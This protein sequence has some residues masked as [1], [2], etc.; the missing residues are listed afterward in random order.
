M[1][2]VPGSRPHRGDSALGQRSLGVAALKEEGPALRGA[3]L[4]I[5]R[6]KCGMMIGKAT[7]AR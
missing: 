3:V 6:Y 7:I 4:E 2:K 5:A 1:S